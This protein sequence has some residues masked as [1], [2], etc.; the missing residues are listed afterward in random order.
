MQ[1]L[2]GFSKPFD[3]EAAT[4]TEHELAN[5]TENVQLENLTNIG[6][7]LGELLGELFG[8]LFGELLG[9]LLGEQLEIFHEK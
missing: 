9:E 7:L 5:F 3:L 2:E 4:L 8:E 1:E 6:P